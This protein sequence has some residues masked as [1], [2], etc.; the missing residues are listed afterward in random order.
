M[1][2]RK[3]RME[4]FQMAFTYIEKLW[5]QNTYD[6]EVIRKIYKEVIEN[7]DDFFFFIFDDNKVRGLCHGTYFNTFWLSGKTC[8]LSSIITNE[9]DRGKG[10]GRKMMDHAKELAKARG[11]KGIILDSA[12]ERK[13]AH[14]FYEIYGFEKCANAYKL[15]L[16]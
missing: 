1:E 4:D 16:E 12:M 7:D 11:C 10:Y 8:Y 13:D 2:F 5:P 3:G 14:R 15:N 6:K 9:E